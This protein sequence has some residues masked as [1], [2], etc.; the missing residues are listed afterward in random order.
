[1]SNY[2]PRQQFQ[3]TKVGRYEIASE[4]GQGGHAIVY[5]AHDPNIKRQV[6]VKI[7]KDSYLDDEKFRERFQRE[8]ETVA[9]LEHPAIV[10]VYDYGKENLGR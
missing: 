8:V 2:T 10:P 5:K 1:M 3:P 7:L 9:K 6:A 4:L